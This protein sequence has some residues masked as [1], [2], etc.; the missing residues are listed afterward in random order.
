MPY[1]LTSAG[2]RRLSAESPQDVVEVPK[3]R[4]LARAIRLAN[5]HFRE[6]QQRSM[7]LVPL[8]PQLPGT[9]LVVERPK[10]ITPSAHTSFLAQRLRSIKIAIRQET[11]RINSTIVATSAEDTRIDS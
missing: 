3:L 8:T 5:L 1:V 9:W 10:T 2:C 6:S 11:V 4:A 7:T